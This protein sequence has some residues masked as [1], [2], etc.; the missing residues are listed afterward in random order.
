[1][2]LVKTGNPIITLTTDF[3][4][5]DNYTGIVKGVL[6]GLNPAAKIIDITHAVPPFNVTA[7][8]YLL[9]T[10]CYSF[11]PGTIHLA[12]V[13]PG[14]G[15]GRR[16]ILIETNNYFFIGPDNGLFSFLRKK[17]IRRIIEI[18]NKKYL[19]GEISHTFHARDIFTPVAG[20]LSLGIAPDEFGPEMKSL[21]IAQPARNRKTK[22]GLIGYLVYIDHFGNL[23][24]SLQKDKLPDS[25][26]AVYLNNRKI[27]KLRKT[28]GLVERGK[29]VCYISSFGYL[30]IGIR[31]G[32]AAA[33]FGIDY[34]TNTEILIAAC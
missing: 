20:F 3:G 10:A 24:T 6:A 21:Q 23:V 9:E 1:M 12:V 8:R 30:E 11:P 16:A 2:A 4:I 22:R 28:F 7:G 5:A 32:S 19:A 18:R 15:T 29:P 17:D 34:D 31:E 13:D 25:R 14:V 27:G 26:F 33:Y